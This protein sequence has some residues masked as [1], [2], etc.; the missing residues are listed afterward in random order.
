MTTVDEEQ[1][2]WRVE[3]TRGSE[4][5]WQGLCCMLAEGWWVMAHQMN[6]LDLNS[7]MIMSWVCYNSSEDSWCFVNKCEEILSQGQA[8]Y[9]VYNEW[10]FYFHHPANFNTQTMLRWMRVLHLFLLYQ[11]YH[12]LEAGYTQYLRSYRWDPGSN[13]SS[14][15]LQVKCWTATP[16]MSTHRNSVLNK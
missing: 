5:K 2:V 3:L 12:D 6:L 15:A 13:P 14:L 10:A 7:E 11:S 8:Q 16:Q 4:L 9:T 1:R